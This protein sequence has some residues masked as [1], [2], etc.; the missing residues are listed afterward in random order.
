MFN[1][2][3]FI[4]KVDTN[5]YLAY[6]T[7]RD[8]A[9]RFLLCVSWEWLLSVVW[10]SEET[11]D[12][13]PGLEEE[14]R[15]GRRWQPEASEQTFLFFHG[16]IFPHYLHVLPWIQ[17]QWCSLHIHLVSTYSS[18]VYVFNL[19]ILV[20]AVYI[21]IPPSTS[22]GSQSLHSGMIYQGLIFISFPFCLTSSLFFLLSTD[23][24]SCVTYSPLV[25]NA[26]LLP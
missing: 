1:N 7:E 14:Q 6:K 10:N 13:C 21:Q 15:R 16:C 24:H 19:G 2:E 25:L 12:P 18:S 4:K 11:R 26:S 3:T 5:V 8:K 9:L 17:A 20:P 22:W 23:C